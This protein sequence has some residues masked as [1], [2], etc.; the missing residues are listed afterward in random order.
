MSGYQAIRDEI[1]MGEKPY[2][3]LDAGQLVKHALALRSE[4]H[5]QGGNLSPVLYYVYAEP[6][7]WPRRGLVRKG[8]KGKGPGQASPWH[9]PAGSALELAS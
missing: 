4:V 8:R 7:Q 2:H 3:F 6:K 9:E 1:R 5:R